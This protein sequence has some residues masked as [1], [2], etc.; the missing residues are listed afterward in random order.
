MQQRVMAQLEA[1]SETRRNRE[2]DQWAEDDC[3]TRCDV[4]LVQKA[5]L[6]ARQCHSHDSPVEEVNHGI[7]PDSFVEGIDAGVVI[8]YGIVGRVQAGCRI[9][10][11]EHSRE[12]EG[13]TQ[14]D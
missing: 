1:M 12:S 14:L 6:L 5:A 13:Q 9:D 8:L 11:A 7:Y 4:H 10:C 2:T 3:M